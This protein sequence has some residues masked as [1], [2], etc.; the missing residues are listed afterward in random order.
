[1]KTDFVVQPSKQNPK[2]KRAEW[3]E[4]DESK[5][6]ARLEQELDKVHTKQKVK[7]IEVGRRIAAS[8][9][10]VSDVVSRLDNGNR[11]PVLRLG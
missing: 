4:E 7:A 10:E 3:T 1:L 11:T 5:F 6:L 8:E 9:K 2:G